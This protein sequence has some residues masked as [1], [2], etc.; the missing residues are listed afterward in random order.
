[1][2]QT[3][4]VKGSSGYDATQLVDK[5]TWSGRKGAAPRC[6][7]VTLLD[8][9]KRQRI[10]V[11]CEEGDMCVLYENGNE[12]FRGAIIDHGQGSSKVLDIVAYDNA[13][14][15][16]NSKDSF[17]YT[18]HTA[19]QIFNDCLIRA[20]M[21]GGAL[22]DTGFVIPELPKAKTTFYDVIL[23]ALSTTY[24]NTGI[25]YYVSSEKGNI[26]LRQRSEDIMQWVLEVGAN[27]Y[28]YSYKKSIS[29]IKTR[30]RLLSKEDAVVYETANE[31]LEAKIGVFTEIKSLNE[32]YNEAQIREL[33]D[34]VFSEKGMP[35]RTLN[36]SGLGITEAI[37]GKAVYVIIPHLGIQR[38]FYIDEDT[39]EYVG[40][41]HTMKLKLNFAGDINAAG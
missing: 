31:S 36:V 19:S 14:H 5:I 22:V 29:G 12:I 37:S 4:I 6:A 20:G 28:D 10:S 30:I 33:V 15:L 3:V 38:T 7:K 32:D 39:H 2:L 40:N 1:M 35:Q 27:I 18:N 17:C 11:D 41:K 16:A 21:P 25:R 8:D 24:K 23:D 34:S 9:D 13:Y 26:Y